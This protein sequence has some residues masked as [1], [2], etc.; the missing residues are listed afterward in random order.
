M[1]NLL[2]YEINLWEKGI[3]TVVGIDEAG[4]G[5]LAGPMV[6][7]AVIFDKSTFKDICMESEAYLKNYEVWNKINDSK[8]LTPK[9]RNILYEFILTESRSYSIIEISETEIDTHKISKATQLGFEKIIKKLKVNPQH[10]LTDH[11]GINVVD[12]K[13]QTN[14]TKGDSKSLSIAAASILAK[15]HRDRIMQ[16]M[17]KK[18]PLYGFNKHKGY[19]TKK[20]R[21]AIAKYG[22]CEIHRN[23]FKLV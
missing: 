21:H 10:F 6:M 9:T 4:R 5:P 20:H 19:G 8:K 12:Q 15:V 13:N 14:I 17:H 18:Y 2:K 7:A 1:Y 16:K 11:F 3:D 22:P 23:S